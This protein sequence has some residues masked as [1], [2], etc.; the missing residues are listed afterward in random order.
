MGHRL[1]CG[2]V[3]YAGGV[4]YVRVDPSTG[5]G[6]YW[7]YVLPALRGKH[8]VLDFS[9]LGGSP[10]SALQDVLL[11]A[12]ML[13]RQGARLW[14]TMVPPEVVRRV[15]SQKAVIPGVS[16][17]DVLAP[18]HCPV[19]EAGRP[20]IMPVDE[21]LHERMNEEQVDLG[22]PPCP[23]CNSAMRYHDDPDT[24]FAFLTRLDASPDVEQVRAECEDARSNADAGPA[25]ALDAEDSA[26]VDRSWLRHGVVYR[27]HG[28]SDK[29]PIPTPV[30][31]DTVAAVVL[32]AA[33]VWLAMWLVA[34]L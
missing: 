23:T 20:I 11:L 2:V 15:A 9:E 34:V 16:C 10:G 4:S 12:S 18:F 8:L 27:R 26:E 3:G 1:N 19:C 31:I 5:P 29:R 22:S 14:L 7:H 33:N 24:L 6:P 17:L 21:G 13:Q 28:R 25:A 30:L 32:L